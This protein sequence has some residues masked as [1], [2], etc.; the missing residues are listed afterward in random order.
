[1]RMEETI[2]NPA[3]STRQRDLSLS[4]GRARPARHSRNIAGHVVFVLLGILT[5]FPIYWMFVSSLRPGGFVFNATFIP[6]A[7]TLQN[8]VDAW[9]SIPILAMLRTTFVMSVLVMVGQVLIGVFAGYAFARWRFRGDRLLFLF[10]VGTWLIPLQVTMI[11]NYVLLSRLGWL[12]SMLA[13]VLPQLSTAFGIILMRQHMKSFPDDLMAA[14]TIDGAGSWRTLWKIM[15]P[16]IKA[17]IAALAILMFISSWN[18]YFWPLLVVSRI[19]NSV[20]Q[21]GLQMFLTE[22]GDLWGPLMAAATISSVPIFVIY[23][24]LRRQVIE[25]FVRSG[26]K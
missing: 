24:V 7:V 8:Y 1:M 14:A 22:E 20:I 15:I 6:R 13:L 17:P 19:E 21:V 5:L 26:I 10:F 18:E 12:D 25:A 9:Q 16:N 4:R 2:A 23:L 3:T 11:P